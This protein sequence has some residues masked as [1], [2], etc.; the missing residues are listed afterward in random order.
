V[1]CLPISHVPFL[2][3]FC[4]W[5]LISP[6][7]RLQ[8]KRACKEQARLTDLAYQEMQWRYKATRK[9][10]FTFLTIFA[11]IDTLLQ[12]YIHA[13]SSTRE[14][15]SSIPLVAH[16]QRGRSLFQ[17]ATDQARKM[18]LNQGELPII[19]TFTI[20]EDNKIIDTSSMPLLP[21]VPQ[22]DCERFFALI[23]QLTSWRQELQTIWNK[24]G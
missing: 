22:E 13:L 1:W 10:L 19:D 3:G 8:L 11:S 14:D 7:R 5:Q 24:Q 12:R 23:E 18:V 20:D 9:A 15:K 21:I 17:D 6:E 16:I 2:Y 4:D